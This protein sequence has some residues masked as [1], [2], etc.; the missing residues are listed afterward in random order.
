[1]MRMTEKIRT[2]GF[3]RAITAGAFGALAFGAAAMVTPALADTYYVQSTPPVYVPAPSTTTTTTYTYSSPT[4][5]YVEPAP[6]PTVV[7]E[8]HDRGPGVY[9]DTPVINFGIGFH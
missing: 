6:P 5:T 8:H 9:L 7:Y 4:Y 2:R 1:M 3:R